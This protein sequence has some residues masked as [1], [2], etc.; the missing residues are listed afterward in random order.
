MHNIAAFLRIHLT[1]NIGAI[2]FRQLYRKYRDHDHIMYQIQLNSRYVVPSVEFVAQ[3]LSKLH[4]FGAEC[5]FIESEHYPKKLREAYDAPAFIFVR[6]NKALLNQ[7]LSIAI[8]GA[9]NSSAHGNKIAH[10]FAQGLS[11]SGYTIISGMARG[12]DRNAH[13]GGIKQTIAVFGNGLDVI[14]PEENHDIYNDILLNNGL[15]VSEVIMGTQPTPASFPSRNRIV[16]GMSD[17]VLVIEASYK[18]G[19]LITA[20][21]A[22]DYSRDLFVIP[23]SPL[24]SRSRGSNMLIQRGAYLVQEHT[25]ICNEMGLWHRKLKQDDEQNNIQERISVAQNHILDIIGYQS[26]HIDSIIA[27]TAST[28]DVLQQIL[29]LMEIDGLITQ[30]SPGVFKKVI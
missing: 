29:T 8:V 6:G 17:A 14:Y 5:I 24:D 22:V 7:K 16:A 27:C 23:G 18:S 15:H 26:V 25:E 1:K 11:E 9:R 20:N 13:I 4:Q 21:C 2:T 28:P 30:E 12:I 10:T 19:S 3:Q